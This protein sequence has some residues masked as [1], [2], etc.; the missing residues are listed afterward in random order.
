MGPTPR[1]SC[2]GTVAPC[3]C[4]PVADHHHHRKSVLVRYAGRAQRARDEYEKRPGSNL[5]FLLRKRF[6]WMQRYLGPET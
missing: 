3:G 6:E 5:K 4:P 1:L 2:S